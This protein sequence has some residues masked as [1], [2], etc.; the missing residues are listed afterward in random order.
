MNRKQPQRRT[1]LLLA[2]TAAALMFPLAATAYDQGGYKDEDKTMQERAKGMMESAGDAASDLRMHLAIEAQFAMS[3][4]LSAFSIN[5]DVSDGVARLEGDVET[6]TQRELA[7]ELAKSVDGVKQVENRIEVKGD[8]PSFVDRVREGAS[9]ALLTSRVKTR[10]MTSQ[11]TSG[12]AISVESD[13]DVVTLSGEVDSE[14][15]RDLAELIAANTSGVSQVRNE[16]RV[17]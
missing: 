3:D 9:D 2:C 11:N 15:E 16:L 1:S 6:D 10:L 17:N 14:A 8:D 5:T 4:E 7:A 13:G 12:L